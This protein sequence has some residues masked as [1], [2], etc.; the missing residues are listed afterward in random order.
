MALDEVDPH[1]GE[2]CGEDWECDA[3]E[4]TCCDAC[5]KQNHRHRLCLAC[6]DEDQCPVCKDI[7]ETDETARFVARMRP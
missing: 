3:C 7:A 6:A 5:S 1:E 2:L 4:V